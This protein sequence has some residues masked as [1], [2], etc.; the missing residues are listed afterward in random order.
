MPY[1]RAAIGRCGSA[2]R[3]TISS[4]STR[5]PAWIGCAP[6]SIRPRPTRGWPIA[7]RC[8]RPPWK[9]RSTRATSCGCATCVRGWIAWRCVCGRERAAR[10]DL[11][12]P[13]LDPALAAGVR[14]TSARCWPR[15]VSGLGRRRYIARS[16]AFFE[17]TGYRPKAAELMLLLGQ[18]YEGLGDDTGGWQ[19]RPRCRIRLGMRWGSCGAGSSATIHADH[20]C[21][22]AGNGGNAAGALY[23]PIPE[24]AADLA[25]S[26][27]RGW[28][29]VRWWPSSS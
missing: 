20:L 17:Q 25:V 21:A 15:P 28:Y 18:A 6:R 24:L 10:G 16:L 22:A 27:R 29:A 2:R 13:D 19:C 3:S 12:T 8:S 11:T 26:H 1:G 7:R 4:C 14:Q 9:H 5:A 23:R